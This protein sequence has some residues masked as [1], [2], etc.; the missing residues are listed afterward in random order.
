MT[1]R[2]LGL[3][4][5]ITLSLFAI[6][7][8][9]AF[10]SFVPREQQEE[11]ITHLPEHIAPI[12]PFI[13]Q[14]YGAVLLAVAGTISTIFGV[15]AKRNKDAAKSIVNGIDALRLVDPATRT[16]MS[17]HKHEIQNQMTPLA[18]KIVDSE[19]IDS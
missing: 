18:R 6:P 12:A 14:P 9:R 8:C 10:D 3:A 7:G 2:T 5:L 19:R 15:I 13:P 4:S 17:Q 1:L 16:S 11:F